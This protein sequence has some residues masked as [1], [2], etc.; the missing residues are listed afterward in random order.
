[1]R[2]IS[3]QRAAFGGLTGLASAAVELLEHQVTVIRRVLAD[4]TERYLLAD[5]VGLGKTIEAGIL[6]RQHTIDHPNDAKV[7]VIVPEHL[8]S[9]WKDELQNKFFLSRSRV[10]LVTEAAL[11]TGELASTDRTMLVVDEAHR[12]AQRAFSG[13]PRERHAYEELRSLSRSTPRLLLLS[14]TPVLHQEDGFLAM[15]HLLDPDA[16]PLDDRDAFRQRVSE[17]QSVAEAT[18]DLMDDASSY[19]AEDADQSDREDLCFRPTTD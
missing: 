13:D 7:L 12:T 9:Q 2:H 18:A 17:R 4:P 15:L 5:E 16:Y 6:I 14:G 10:E 1:M 11:L 19:F 8:L 3:A